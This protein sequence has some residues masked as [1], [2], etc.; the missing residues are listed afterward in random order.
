MNGRIN[1]IESGKIDTFNG[2]KEFVSN[3][4]ML[5]ILVELRMEYYTHRQELTELTQKLP[6]SRQRREEKRNVNKSHPP[7]HRWIVGH[8]QLQLKEDGTVAL[9]MKDDIFIRK[10]VKNSARIM[11]SGEFTSSVK[12]IRFKNV[13]TYC[14]PSHDSICRRCGQG[15]DMSNFS[16]VIVKKV[17]KQ[18]YL[19][20]F[21]GMRYPDALLALEE[22]ENANVDI[23][24]VTTKKGRELVFGERDILPPNIVGFGDMIYFLHQKCHIKR[25]ALSPAPI[26]SRRVVVT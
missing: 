20:E 19:N 16:D 5:K 12:N 2:I 6:T 7:L 9:A 22:R 11:R 10:R 3:L 8:G 25:T 14:I 1:T 15:W 13:P 24:Y 18:L 26:D 23:R 21:S 17:F 4:D